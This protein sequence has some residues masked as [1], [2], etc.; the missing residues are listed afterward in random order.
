MANVGRQCIIGAGSVV[1][2]D[3]S[4]YIYRGWKSCKDYK[5]EAI[6]LKIIEIVEKSIC[7]YFL[8][9]RLRFNS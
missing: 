8:S 6:D 3:L 4:D 1:T 2:K 7:E 5:K 9:I